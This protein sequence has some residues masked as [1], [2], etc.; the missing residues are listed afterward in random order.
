MRL[1]GK[2]MT[3]D[4]SHTT[5]HTW[6]VTYHMTYA[7]VPVWCPISNTNVN[8]K[9]PNNAF[10]L[11]LTGLLLDHMVVVV[12]LFVVTLP[13]LP[14]AQNGP[15][16]QRSLKILF[17]YNIRQYQTGQDHT[18]LHQ[19]GRAKP[20]QTRRDHFRPINIWPYKT[21]ATRPVQSRRDHRHTNIV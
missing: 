18:R 3:Y 4:K 21:Y 1:L 13:K 10:W 15:N 19:T 6:Q 12:H 11:V 14:H 9:L 16:G 20:N 5:Y 17:P 7:I 2:L 8:I